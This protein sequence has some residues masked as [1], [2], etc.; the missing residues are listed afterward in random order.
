MDLE[1]FSAHQNIKHRNI[2]LR[3]PPGFCIAAVL[4][5]LAIQA[6]VLYFFGQPLISQTH[7]LML[8][9]AD[10]LSAENSQQLSDWY[11]ASHVIHGFIFYGLLWYFFRRLTIW[12][13]LA[14]AV[15]IEVA[16]E[17]IENTPLVINYY[18]QQALAQ[19][20]VGDSIINSISD[21]LAMIA[22]FFFAWR[23][24]ILLT[25]A[26]GVGLEL[27]VGY[28]IHDNLFLNILGFAWTP[29]FIAEWQ[30]R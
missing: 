26:V 4:C 19:G 30:S 21:T 15:G 22:G 3:F 2:D 23:F 6:F 24:P 11:T 1:E 17:I 12:Q 16:W 20:Y 27:W 7:S 13:R 9:A 28:W 29:D 14:L 8:W 10:V 5:L 25:I 18:R